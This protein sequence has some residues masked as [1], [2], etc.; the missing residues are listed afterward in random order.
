MATLGAAPAAQRRPSPLSDT[1]RSSH[2]MSMDNL[3]QRAPAALAQ[4][5]AY[6]ID[7]SVYS[8]PQTPA[9]AVSE[10]S[11]TPTTPHGHPLS[12]PFSHLYG[13]QRTQATPVPVLAIIPLCIARVAEGL[14]FAVIFR[15]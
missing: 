7:T 11:T 15:A 14:I 12:G 6:G 5:H 3:L 13:P 1:A 8:P 2:G 4:R 10:M 9:S